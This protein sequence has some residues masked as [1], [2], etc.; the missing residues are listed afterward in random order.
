MSPHV[1]LNKIVRA[2][3]RR[4]GSAMGW[5]DGRDHATVSR[6][7]KQSSRPMGRYIRH[8]C[9]DPG[10]RNKTQRSRRDLPV[11]S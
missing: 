1:L 6:R 7:G 2:P 4:L 3:M 11:P 9:L 5:D 10:H 8:A